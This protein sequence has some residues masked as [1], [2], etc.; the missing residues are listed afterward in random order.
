MT[1]IIIA[2][3]YI[4]NSYVSCIVAIAFVDCSR[5]FLD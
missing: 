1:F 2:Y 5:A 3:E 4:E